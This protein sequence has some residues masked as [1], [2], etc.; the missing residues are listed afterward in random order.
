MELQKYYS[1]YIYFF[2]KEK[3]KPPTLLEQI[4]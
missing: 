3:E 4:S 2:S 1:S